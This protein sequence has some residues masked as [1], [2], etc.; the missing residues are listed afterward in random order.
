[1]EMIFLVCGGGAPPALTQEPQELQ[2]DESSLWDWA[3]NLC[4]SVVH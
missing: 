4:S 3:V 1:M 2:N